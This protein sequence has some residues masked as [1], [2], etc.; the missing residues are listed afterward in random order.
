MI[1]ATWKMEPL[2]I[3]ILW[4][5]KEKSERKSV[6]LDFMAGEMDTMP[7]SPHI[8]GITREEIADML[9]ME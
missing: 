5:E 2:S 8:I 4:M 1:L 9:Q 6:G 3:T 7:D